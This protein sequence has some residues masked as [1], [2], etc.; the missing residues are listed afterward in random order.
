MRCDQIQERIVE[1]LYND[2]GTPPSEIQDHVR[3]CPACR[4]ELEEL[5]QT[6]KHLQAWKDEAPLRSVAIT[7]REGLLK[8]KTGWS[9]AGYAAIAA[10]ALICFLA[11]AN[12]EITV[13]R[14]EF[15]FSTSLFSKKNIRQ[16]YYTKEEARELMKRALDDSELRMSEINYLMVQRMLDT[17]EQ[18]QQMDLR[19]MRTKSTQNSN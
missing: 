19:F 9:Y 3:T 1:L 11:L 6:R 13:N 15:K 18:E 5:E 7:R 12:T 10:M 4:R 2:G 16:D 17:V 14:N 8:R